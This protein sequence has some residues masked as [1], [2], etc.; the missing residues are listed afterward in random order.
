MLSVPAAKADWDATWRNW[1]RRETTTF[2]KQPPLAKGEVRVREFTTTEK[3]QANGN[4][5]F[6]RLLKLPENLRKTL[7][8]IAA[9]VQSKG[10]RRCVSEVWDKAKAAILEKM[11]VAYVKCVNKH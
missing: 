1:C 2:Q 11:K 4:A 6:M 10:K 5:E 8:E 7:D 9:M 3:L